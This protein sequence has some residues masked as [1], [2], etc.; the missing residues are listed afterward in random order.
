MRC[1]P[2]ASTPST[3][4]TTSRPVPATTARDSTAACA[5]AERATCSSSGSSTASVATLP[6]W[7]TL[8]RPCRPAAWACGCSPGKARRSI[9]PPRHLRVR[10]LRELGI[11]PVT[12]YRYVGPHTSSTRRAEPSLRTVR[13][14]RPGT[15]WRPT[16]R[17][18]RS[19]AGAGQRWPIAPGTAGHARQRRRAPLPSSV[20]EVEIGASV[21]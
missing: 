4:T 10:A 8:C 2:R 6:T 14:S 13:L 7:S 18:R 11:T 21:D 9:P 16:R 1:R 15:R 12:L 19:T 20:S 5:R 3:S 17:H